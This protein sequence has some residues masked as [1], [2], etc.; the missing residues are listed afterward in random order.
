MNRGESTKRSSSAECDSD[1]QA[2]AASSRA[3]S[4]GHRGAM[5][6]C[7]HPAR[8]QA[9]RL[10]GAHDRQHGR[11][12]LD[13]AI[14]CDSGDNRVE[15]AKRLANC[16]AAFCK[17]APRRV[18]RNPGRSTGRDGPGLSSCP[19]AESPEIARTT[20]MSHTVARSSFEGIALT[21]LHGE[22][23]LRVKQVAGPDESLT[24]P[25]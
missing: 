12:R 16:R 6:D 10:R 9:L 8:A 23:W 25:S 13:P 15:P 5:L 18:R 2:W 4:L 21:R 19:C 3:G 20:V 22:L 14:S 17:S 1:H 24:Q 11:G 7:R